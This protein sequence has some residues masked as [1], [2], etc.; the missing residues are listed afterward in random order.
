MGTGNSVAN[1]IPLD[2]YRA[3]I[4]EGMLHL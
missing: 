4:N 3:I 1:C 2:N